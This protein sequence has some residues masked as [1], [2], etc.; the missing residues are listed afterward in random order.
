MGS[1][2]RGLFRAC[3][4]SGEQ[5]SL[6]EEEEEQESTKLFNICLNSFNPSDLF[7]FPLN[8][9]LIF[10]F[11]QAAAAE[12]VEGHTDAVLDLSWNKLVKSVFGVEFTLLC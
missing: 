8:C 4:L 9:F 1:G 12:P 2:C 5:K 7:F 6:Q 3:F 11:L 10:L